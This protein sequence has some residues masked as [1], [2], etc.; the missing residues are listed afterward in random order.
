MSSVSF[1]KNGKHLHNVCV[2]LTWYQKIYLMLKW[3]LMHHDYERMHDMR[4]SFMD[5]DRI[6]KSLDPKKD[7]VVVDIGSGDGVFSLKLSELVKIVYPVDV[8]TSAHKAVEAKIAE[9]KVR[10]VKPYIADVCNG[11][12]VSGF[13]AVIFVTSFHDLECRA[14]IL[15]EIKRKHSGTLKISITEFKKEGTAMGP[16]VSIR[17]SQDELDSIFVP[18]GFVSVYHDEFGPLYINRYEL[19]KK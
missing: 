10:N 4:K 11:L 14:T 17:M 15:E 12:P 9:S 1:H 8:S 19:V 6:I 18:E 16:P 3:G 5:F 2:F 7:D 13:N